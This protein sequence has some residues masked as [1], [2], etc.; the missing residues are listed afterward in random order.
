VITN[1]DI[2]RAQDRLSP[3][4]GYRKDAARLAV[5]PVSAGFCVVLQQSYFDGDTWITDE[6]PVGDEYTSRAEATAAFRGL[7]SDW[8]VVD[9]GA[10]REV[11]P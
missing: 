6:W 2:Q 11:R 9:D 3:R 5:E 7:G 1:T 4:H 8:R 10:V